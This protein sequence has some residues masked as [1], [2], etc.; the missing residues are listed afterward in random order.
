MHILLIH[1]AFASSKQAG[2]TR[3]FEFAQRC[4]NHDHQFSIVS[5]NL[6]YID[7][8]RTTSDNRLVTTEIAGGVKVLRVYTYAA[9]HKSFIWRVISF[10]SFM[11]TSVIG[12]M[13]AENVDMVMGTSP[14]IF[15]AVSAWI[16]AKI[17]RKPFL[18]EIR[19]LWPEFAVDMGVLKNPLLIW[20]SR[21]LEK[22]LYAQASHLLVNSPAYREYLIG[23]GVSPKKISLISNG[24]DPDMFIPEHRGN[25]FRKEYGL[26]GKFVVTYA[27]ALGMANDIPTILSAA[28]KLKGRPDI[29]F[30]IVGDGKERKALERRSQQKGLENI[31]FTGP[32]PKNEMPEVLAASDAC[33]ATLMDIP[34]F[35]TTYPNKV[36]DYMAAGR[37]TVL[38]IDGVIRS[39]V[40]SASG[41]IYVPPGD[42]AALAG[43]VEKLYDDSDLAKSMGASARSYVVKHFN[44][45]HQAGQFINLIES[46]Q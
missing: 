37:P 14:P 1:Q 6:S 22:L 46:V 16:T 35:K 33:L 3:H 4:I 41:G 15:Q 44:R 34:M 40:E 38:G 7:G 28:E 31:T 43:A 45:N 23:K 20:L 17:K 29:H 25:G 26:N 8:K 21:A 13:R 30:T 12:A 27:G 2:G 32:R 42:A 11:V 39:V 5:S 19:D 24:V 18:L 10:L 9:L 36:F